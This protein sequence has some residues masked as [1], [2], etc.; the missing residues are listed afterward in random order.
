MNDI[1]LNKQR[2]LASAELL[3]EV[4]Q[5]RIKMENLKNEVIK[6]MNDRGSQGQLWTNGQCA[7]W[8]QYQQSLV[9]LAEARERLLV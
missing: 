4:R 3:N 9:D 1:E 7:A 6:E 5:L 2:A 8:P